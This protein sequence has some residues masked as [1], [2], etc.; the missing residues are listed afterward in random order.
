MR[1]HLT[2]LAALL[3][4]LLSAC[5][6]PSPT[7]APSTPAPRAAT[8]ELRPDLETF[9][10]AQGIPA[11]D[12]AF[13]LY[14]RGQNHWV[15]YNPQRCA[16]R[17]LPASTFKIL[18]SLIAL[19]TGAIPD[20]DTTIAWDGVQYPIP[21]WNRDQTMRSAIRDSVVWYYQELA[22][23][24][25]RE[26]MQAYVTR[27]AY[28]NMDISGEIDS[29][30]LRGGL[31][32]SPDEQIDFLRRFYQNDLPFSRRSLDLVKDILIREQAPAY[33]LRSKTGT[34]VL[35]DLQIGWL[36][37]YVETPDTVYF[38]A[39][40][41]QAAAPNSAGVDP[42]LSSAREAITRGILEELKVLP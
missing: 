1:P 25:G 41:L 35:G 22:R 34:A 18:N 24:V 28:G 42:Q 3:I 26:K 27:S 20:A 39:T 7:P 5:S 33:T 29:F 11:A 37:G 23:R 13:V 12:G 19:E 21:E 31:R 40:N 14:N 10:T 8:S 36:V 4:L 16:E 30:W 32:I 9:F 17:F 2:R 15:R 38:F 6:T